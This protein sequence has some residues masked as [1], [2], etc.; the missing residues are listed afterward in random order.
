[1]VSL[2]YDFCHADVVRLARNGIDDLEWEGKADKGAVELRKKAVVE[3]FPSSETVSLPGERHSWYDGE[4]DLGIAGE[5]GA[6]RLFDAEEVRGAERVPASV[7]MQFKL[8]RN[9]ASASL[10][11]NTYPVTNLAVAKSRF[12]VRDLIDILSVYRL[13][14]VTVPEIL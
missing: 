9:G 5:Q 1:M 6:L 11:G 8:C 10:Y 3:S 2:V 7:F 4:V 14:Q 12:Y 13:Y